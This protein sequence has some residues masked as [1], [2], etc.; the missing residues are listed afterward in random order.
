VPGDINTEQKILDAAEDVFQEK[1]YDGARMQEIAERAGINKGLLHY[2]FKTKD[3]LFDGIFGLAINRL[4][5]K[6]TGILELDIP[7][8][9]K[10]DLVIDQYMNMLLKK[11]ALPKFVLNELNK[12]PD[13]FIA[14]HIGK[15][16]RTS[17]AGFI[18]SVQRDVD[19][20]KIREIDPYQLFVN[21]M[22][23]L[24]FPFVG[25]PLLQGVF[26]MGNDEFKKLMTARKAHIKEFIW[27][28]IK[29]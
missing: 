23:L 21:I 25:R 17:F 10:I 14:R 26:A 20:K 12:N 22:S 11:P 15:E 28:S 27:Q 29:V 24:I 13:K 16:A 7:L 9:E 1:G 19:N 18:Q 3:T 5:S 8:D 4:I 6:I 2:Y